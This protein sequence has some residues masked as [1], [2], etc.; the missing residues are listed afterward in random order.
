MKV[1]GVFLYGTGQCVASP[2]PPSKPFVQPTSPNTQRDRGSGQAPSSI[3]ETVDSHAS[4]VVF[5]T[6][7]AFLV[8]YLWMFKEPGSRV[9]FWPSLRSGCCFF[10]KTYHPSPSMRRLHPTES[11]RLHPAEEEPTAARKYV[12]AAV[13]TALGAES[14]G[15]HNIPRGGGCF[16]GRRKECYGFS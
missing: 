15:G 5:F 12:V 13:L 3:V 14:S 9:C 4:S 7:H 11:L 6:S 16:V 1:M 8:F 10:R 2:P